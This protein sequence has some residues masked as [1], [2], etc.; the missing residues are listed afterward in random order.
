MNKK[1]NFI[2]ALELRNFQGRTGTY[3]FSPLTV[4]SGEPDKGK[5][6]LVA[7]IHW[8]LAGSIPGVSKKPGELFDDC[9][10]GAEMFAGAS[11]GNGEVWTRRAVLSDGSV[12]VEAKRD[13]TKIDGSF[14]PTVAL[15]SRE[16]L[17]LSDRERSRMIFNFVDKTKIKFDVDTITGKIK[18]VTVETPTTE[19][20]AAIADVVKVIAESWTKKGDATPQEWLAG[21]VMAKTGFFAARKSQAN[22]AAKQMQATI[23]ADLTAAEARPISPT[24]DRE[25]ARARAEH[26][27][28]SGEIATLKNR[29]EEAGKRSK[30]KAQLEA[31][32]GTPINHTEKIAQLTAEADALR[33]EVTAY[34]SKVPPAMAEQARIKG[35]HSRAVIRKNEVEQEIAEIEQTFATLAEK[36]CCP[37]CSAKDKELGK[38]VEKLKADAI[39]PLLAESQE[40]DAKIPALAKMLERCQKS[41]EAANKA[42]ADVQQKHKDCF[43]K[44]REAEK[45]QREMG[46]FENFQSELRGIGEIEDVEKLESE[47]KK[48]ADSLA[49]FAT[50]INELDGEQRQAIAARGAAQQRELNKKTLARYEADLE[51]AK[52]AEKVVEETLNDLINATI[53]PLVGRANEFAEPV[54][55]K[56]L[57]FR[58]GI[59]GFWNG[60]HFA[61]HHRFAGTFKAVSYVALS[62]A[63]VPESPLR[64][65]YIDEMGIM[66][67]KYRARVLNT[68]QELIDAGKLD[69]FIGIDWDGAAYKVGGSLSATPEGFS[70]IEL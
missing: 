32:T 40:L 57:V 56:K 21:L 24:I 39:S 18:G 8:L 64:V 38:R 5:T 51:V 16:Y 7:G 25:L 44:S 9:A 27:K 70:L 62:L 10:T 65:L 67:P 31:L 45:L 59:F 33:A 66:P 29:I 30:R 1:R 46:A 3:P 4:I 22:T 41:L 63:L 23:N 13:G 50:K 37:T 15:D 48:L 69:Q 19:T 54:I 55:Q 14:I 43:E 28:I 36:K 12:K 42:D 34:K 61:K 58:D 52:L 17:G 35:E 20:E 68:A 60:E 11:L 2:A 49:A 26:T 6:T 47:G 53:S